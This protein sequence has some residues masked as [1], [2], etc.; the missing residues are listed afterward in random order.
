LFPSAP[1]PRLVAAA[2]A[3]EEAGLDEFWLGDE[4]PAARDA[5]AVLAAVAM[6]TTRIRLGIA[7]T[8]PYLRHAAV[9]AAEMMTV[10]E[11][12]GGRALLGLGPGGRMALGPARVERVAP[13]AAA[14]QALATMRAVTRGTPAEG[15][16][17]GPAP[18]VAPDLP[19]YIGSRGE[20]FN[21]LASAEADGVF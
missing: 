12:A 4:G 6:R 13:L 10:H 1:A 17:P 3:A 21:R 5:F 20:Q 15:F 7:I 18:F 16:A 2:A 11:L 19:L 9:A 8:N 14:R